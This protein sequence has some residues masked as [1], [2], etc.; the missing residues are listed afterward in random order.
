MLILPF[1]LFAELP[2]LTPELYSTQDFK[3]LGRREFTEHNGLIYV[4]AYEPTHGEELWVFDGSSEGFRILKDI[5]PYSSS[6]PIVVSVALDDYM[7]FIADDSTETDKTNRKEYNS[8][9]ATNGNETIKIISSFFDYYNFEDGELNDKQRGFVFF[10]DKVYFITNT[11]EHITD[12]IELWST[13]GTIEGTSKLQEFVYKFL[14]KMII[15]DDKLVVTFTN[16][17]DNYE[18]WSTNDSIDSLD[19]IIVINYPVESRLNIFDHGIYIPTSYNEYWFTNGTT[20]GTYRFKSLNDYLYSVSEDWFISGTFNFFLAKNKN[21]STSLWVSDGTKNGTN[22]LLDF[23]LYDISELR[24][25]TISGKPNKY[26]YFTTTDKNTYLTSMWCT[27]GTKKETKIIFTE[28]KEYT[29]FPSF[30]YNDTLVYTLGT[31][32][33]VNR[34]TY[35]TYGYSDEV[36]N[37]IRG[38]IVSSPVATIENKF[39]FNKSEEDRTYTPWITDLT[40]NGT[41][42]LNNEISH[43]NY[44]NSTNVKRYDNQIFFQFYNVINDMSNIL[45]YKTDLISGISEKILPP[46]LKRREELHPE[47]KVIYF[48]NYIYFFANYYGEE[49]QLYRIPNTISSVEDTPQPE[50][51]TVYPNP[52]KDYIQLELDKPIQL[53]VV[54]STGALVKDYGIVENDKLNVA[55]LHSGVYFVVDEQGNNIAKFVKE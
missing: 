25:V 16:R 20:N 7:L 32:S 12:K 43:I 6:E 34:D 2:I 41:R 33:S 18:V 8:L 3:N 47:T 13:D 30:S 49:V 51:M 23:D 54:N 17:S 37:K 36:I 1:S 4:N 26:Y 46:R 55:E 50:L 31:S 42:I 11:R 40:E 24:S 44:I 14:D 52:A 38:V 48:K 22:E 5:N 19:S 10:K 21:N 28:E 15:V 39:L 9:W 53:S 35:V 29:L 27:D 45:S